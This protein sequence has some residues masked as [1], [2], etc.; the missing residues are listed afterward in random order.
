MG[1]VSLSSF[2]G[3]SPLGGLEPR[4]AATIVA[5]PGKPKL[6][7]GELALGDLVVSNTLE[8]ELLGRV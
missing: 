5:G 6:V 4:Q 7:Q 8:V 2:G 1:P 3:A